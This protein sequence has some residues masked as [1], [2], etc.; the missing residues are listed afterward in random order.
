MVT[1]TLLIKLSKRAPVVF[2]FGCIPYFCLHK[3][4]HRCHQTR[5]LGS[6]IPEMLLRPGFCPG[7]AGGAHSTPWDP[8]VELRGLLLRVL[9][10]EEGK[11][12]REREVQFPTSSVLLW[13]LVGRICGT[14]VFWVWSGRE[15][16]WW[17][18]KV[19]TM[20]QVDL[21]VSGMGW[22]GTRMVRMRLTEC[23]RKFIP[24]TRWYISVWTICD[25]NR[26]KRGRLFSY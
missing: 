5:F 10:G 21:W 26:G 16:E 14:G 12:R 4:Q 1:I 8:L 11:G 20:E 22:V 13:I 9:R 15:C 23:S 25:F 24:K 6:N 18:V 19:V 7:L 3:K 17:M 2:R